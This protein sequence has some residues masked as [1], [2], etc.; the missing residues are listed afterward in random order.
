MTLESAA[1]LSVNLAHNV[2]NHPIP[3]SGARVTQPNKSL[4]IPLYWRHDLGIN[5]NS[6]EPATLAQLG[7]KLAKLKRAAT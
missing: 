6:G 5:W 4:P 1:F 2:M 7:P 3:V